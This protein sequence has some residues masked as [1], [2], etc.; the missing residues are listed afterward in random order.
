VDIYAVD[1]ETVRNGSSTAKA[2]AVAVA[3]LSPPARPTEI[4]LPWAD[5]AGRQGVFSDASHQG[6]LHFGWR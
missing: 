2:F 5:L 6:H 4:G 3:D 1:G